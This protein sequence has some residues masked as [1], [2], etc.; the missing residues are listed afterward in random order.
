MMKKLLAVLIILAL[1]IGGVAACAEEPGS[2]D[3]EDIS[4]A[5][6][7]TAEE[8]EK[9]T[10]KSAYE[11]LTTEEQNAYNSAKNYLDMMSFSKK[12]IIQQLSSEYGD[13]YPEKVAKK[14]V[15]VLE[16]EEKIDWT[17]EAKEAAQNYLDT[18]SF[19]KDGLVKQLES[20]YGDQFTHEEAVAAVEAVY[21]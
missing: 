10:K 15:E 20:E 5:E 1:M 12:G 14:A 18:M 2:G 7:K 11:K 13:N 21:K 19:S 16:K 17:E 9:K 8:T 4:K 3:S 6:E